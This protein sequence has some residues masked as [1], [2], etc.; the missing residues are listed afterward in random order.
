MNKLINTKKKI[1]VLSIIYLIE[2]KSW[3]LI[4]GRIRIHFFPIR[5]HGSGSR[6]K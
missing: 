5:I 6:S 4:L 3:N 2:E 1:M